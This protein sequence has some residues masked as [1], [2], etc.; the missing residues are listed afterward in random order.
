MGK[1]HHLVD[2]EANVFNLEYV[3]VRVLE[4]S[5]CKSK[6]TSLSFST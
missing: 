6:N 4:K 2:R 1:E 3:F 5:Q